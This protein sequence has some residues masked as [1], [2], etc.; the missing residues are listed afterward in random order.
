MFYAGNEIIA[1]FEVFLLSILLIRG[2]SPACYHL[3]CYSLPPAAEL[4]IA[5]GAKSEK[6][7]NGAD[8]ESNPLTECP[9]RALNLI[10]RYR[11]CVYVYARHVSMPLCHLAI[12]MIWLRGL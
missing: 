9:L 7:E 10:G 12:F 2:L 5:D 3:F 8:D 4:E 6:G 11:P 1:D